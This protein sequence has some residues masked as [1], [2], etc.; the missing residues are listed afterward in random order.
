M[1]RAPAM[2]LFRISPS[3]FFYN[4]KALTSNQKETF[5][6]RQEKKKKGKEKFISETQSLQQ[7]PSLPALPPFS[8]FSLPSDLPFKPPQQQWV[9]E[10]RRLFSV[11]F[12]FEHYPVDYNKKVHRDGRE[13]SSVGCRQ[14]SVQ[15][16]STSSLAY[17]WNE[18]PSDE[19]DD[20]LG[21]VSVGNGGNSASHSR[22]RVI[23]ENGR[24]TQ[25]RDQG[26]GSCLTT[27]EKIKGQAKN[28][29]SRRTKENQLDTY[30]HTH[31]P[32][33][34]QLFSWSHRDARAKRHAAPLD[35]TSLFQHPPP[36][37][38]HTAHLP[39]SSSHIQKFQ[40][41][42]FLSLLLRDNALDISDALLED[43]VQDLR[44]LE[45]LVDLADDGLGQLALLA[46]LDL[47]LV[48]D[49]RVQHAL[50]LVGQGRL[51]LELVGLGFELGGFLLTE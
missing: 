21:G 44:V 19:S 32:F 41:Y 1:F 27:S 11:E 13:L 5:Q 3:F 29:R 51:L 25:S 6:I 7:P 16:S 22:F 36:L 37:F 38:I 18:I 33:H 47:A 9:E 31:A 39:P 49:P 14:T 50:G 23:G 2:S 15:S 45:L 48:A 20:I 34:F 28:A 40:K 46:R 35:S 30:I 43:L 8:P 4:V 26:R 12:K 10:R 24:P 17:N 42:N